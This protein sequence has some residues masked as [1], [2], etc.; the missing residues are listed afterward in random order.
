MKLIRFLLMPI[1]FLDRYWELWQYDN[2]ARKYLLVFLWFPLTMAFLIVNLSLL[3]FSR[4]DN[5]NYPNVS[6]L[7]EASWQITASAGSGQVLSASV[8]PAD[9]RALL[10]QEF[11]ERNDSPMA[12][13]ANLIVQEADKNGLDFRLL[14]AIAMCESN[15]GKRMPSADSYNAWGIAVY[16]G[17]PG[18]GRRFAGGWPEAIVWVSNFFKEKFY[19]SGVYDLKDIGAIWAPPS[20]ENG[21]SWTYCVET[22]KQSIL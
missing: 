19:D 2:M 10:L 8:I 12:P 16:N 14:V 15:L 22:F 18:E 6:P 20:V 4:Q 11:L 21:Y 9:A 13:Y 5:N 7:S 3:A 1:V 17:E